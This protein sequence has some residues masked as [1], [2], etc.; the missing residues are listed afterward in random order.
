MVSAGMQVVRL[1]GRLRV[2]RNLVRLLQ[3]GAETN[4]EIMS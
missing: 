1:G 3:Y 4:K 2:V